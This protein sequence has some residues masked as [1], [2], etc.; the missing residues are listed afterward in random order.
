M[1]RDY[2]ELPMESG[3]GGLARVPYKGSSP[4]RSYRGLSAIL[5]VSCPGLVDR[6]TECH[7]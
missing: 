4:K 2:D 1:L 6:S 7:S 3:L 5:Q